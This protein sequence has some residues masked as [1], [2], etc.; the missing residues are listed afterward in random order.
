MSVGQA[1]DERRSPV[2][3]DGGCI[4]R[5]RSGAEGLGAISRVRIGRALH[6]G[7]HDTGAIRPGPPDLSRQPPGL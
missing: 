6:R 4:R 5:Q 3:V 2:D 7:R 1:Q